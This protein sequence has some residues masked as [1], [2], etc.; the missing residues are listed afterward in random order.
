MVNAAHGSIPQLTSSRRDRST[1]GN[2]ARRAHSAA[3][4]RP[5]PKGGMVRNL[6]LP[7]VSGNRTWKF[8]CR[9]WGRNSAFDGVNE[10]VSKHGNRS[11]KAQNRAKFCPVKTEA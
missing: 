4:N 5:D 9:D 8:R 2:K 3:A 11:E 10:P 7:I 1:I 6:F